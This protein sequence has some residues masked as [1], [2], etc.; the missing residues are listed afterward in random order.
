MVGES[1]DSVVSF[2]A[3]PRTH[4][5]G[6]ELTLVAGGYLAPFLHLAAP[7]FGSPIRTAA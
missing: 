2:L 6:Q 7:Q 5:P 3:P 1:A 4:A